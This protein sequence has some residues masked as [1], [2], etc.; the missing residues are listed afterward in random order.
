MIQGQAYCGKCDRLVSSVLTGKREPCTHCG[1]FNWE[2]APGQ[3]CACG[4][5][6]RWLHQ[7]PPEPLEWGIEI[8]QRQVFSLEAV[9]E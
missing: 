4:E 6:L 8:P 2:V 9:P 1:G 5:P 7:P 3:A